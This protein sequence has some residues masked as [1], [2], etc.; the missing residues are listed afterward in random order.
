LN[1]NY[2]NTSGDGSKGK[3]AMLRNNYVEF[4]KLS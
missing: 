4:L 3:I 2:Y 1:R